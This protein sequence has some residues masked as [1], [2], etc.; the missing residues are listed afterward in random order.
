L[1]E[2]GGWRVLP[3]AVRSKHGICAEKVS[4]MNQC[5]TCRFLGVQQ[6]DLDDKPTGF[7]KCDL[8]KHYGNDTEYPPDA[9]AAVEDGS[10]Y[11]AQLVVRGDFGCN[12]WAQKKGADFT[13]GVPQHD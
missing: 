3:S 11:Y 12:Q 10:G 4:V 6:L 1:V 2:L 9:K 5:S 13:A 8:I 7:W